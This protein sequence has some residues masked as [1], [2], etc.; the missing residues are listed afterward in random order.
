[1]QTFLSYFKNKVMDIPSVL[2]LAF[3]SAR[4]QP[5]QNVATKNY[6]EVR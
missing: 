3:K 5:S 2:I 6:S 4:Q 1:M